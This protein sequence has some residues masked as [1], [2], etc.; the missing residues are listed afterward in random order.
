MMWG[1][2]FTLLYLENVNDTQILPK[3]FRTKKGYLMAT[4][5]NLFD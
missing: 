4:F 5:G 3:M 1:Y 2:S